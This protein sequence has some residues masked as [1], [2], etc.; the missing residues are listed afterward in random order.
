M[1]YP[2][3]NFGAPI[4]QRMLRVLERKDSRPDQP[5]NPIDDPLQDH[6]DGG[7]FLGN[8]VLAL[9]IERAIKKQSDPG[10]TALGV[11]RRVLF[12]PG[13]NAGRQLLGAAGARYERT[14]FTVSW[15]PLL[16]GGVDVSRQ[17]TLETQEKDVCNI[18][19]RKVK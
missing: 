4:R 14:L 15:T 2:P 1:L 6:K 3:C 19:I 13:P 18:C 11:F 8:P 9:L 12:L 5:V 16:E 10:I 7:S 17:L